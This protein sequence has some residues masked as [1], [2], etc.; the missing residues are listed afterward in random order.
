M[1]GLANNNVCIAYCVSLFFLTLQILPVQDMVRAYALVEDE[2]GE[3]VAAR[4][5]NA[6][7]MD[8]TAYQVE[9]MLK[10]QLQG[11]TMKDGTPALKEK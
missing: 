6:A 10:E 2:F 1:E 7:T 8:K 5:S 9:R 4:A 3:A 11:L